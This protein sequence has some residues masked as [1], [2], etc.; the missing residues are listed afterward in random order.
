MFIVRKIRA[1]IL[2]LSSPEENWRI[3]IRYIGGEKGDG[4]EREGEKR[5]N[6]TERKAERRISHGRR[7][8]VADSSKGGWRRGVKLNRVN[9]NSTVGR[10]INANRWYILS[11][12]YCSQHRN[13]TRMGGRLPPPLSSLFSRHPSAEY[14][15]RPHRGDARRNPREIRTLA[16]WGPTWRPVKWKF[17]SCRSLPF[18]TSAHLLFPSLEIT[19]PRLRLYLYSNFVAAKCGGLQVGWTDATTFV[20]LIPDNT[21]RSSTWVEEEEV[22]EKIVPNRYV[23]EK[24]IIFW[25]K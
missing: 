23:H 12:P 16:G 1:I 11:S 2:Q 15:P 13:N 5:H 17:P 24:W 6:A 10:H 4:K 25:Y 9:I 20:F 8:V 21:H 18:M 19:R 7:F 3:Y 22:R 14:P